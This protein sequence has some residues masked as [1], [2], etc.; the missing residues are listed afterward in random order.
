MSE[1]TQILPPNPYVGP[2]SF[3]TGEKMYGRDAE[4][5]ELV[6]LLIAERILVLHSPS[7]AGKSSLVQA[8]LIP[9]LQKEDFHVFPILRLNLD[10]PSNCSGQ[11]E[12]NRYAFS[13]MMSLEEGLDDA[14]KHPVE[15]LNAWTLEEYLAQRE[16]PQGEPDSKLLILDQFEEILTVDPNDHTGKTAFFAQLGSLLLNRKYWAL[17]AI[18]EDYVAA[19]DPYLR[20]VPTRLSNHF[21]LDLLAAPAA[22]QAIQK[23]AQEEGV[24]FQP[25]AVKKLVNDLRQIRVQQT[26]GSTQVQSGLYVEPVQLQVVCYNLWQHLP[27]GIKEITLKELS[28]IG[29][30]DQSL[31]NY[32]AE[33]VCSTSE[34]FQLP[35]RRIRNWFEHQLI[36]KQGIRGLVQMDAQESEGLDNRAIRRL[37]NDHLVRSEKRL[38]S[39]WFELAHDRL[40]DP[41]RKNNAVWMQQNLNL[42]QRQAGV[43]SQ[44][45]RPDSLLLQGKDLEDAR[46]WSEAN[47]GAM[48][49]EEKDFL[50]DCLIEEERRQTQRDQQRMEQEAREQALKLEAAESLANSEKRRAEEQ[51][52]AAKSLRQRAVFLAMALVLALG[53]AGVAYFLSRV[54]TKESNN[55]KLQ[56]VNAEVQRQ[57]AVDAKSIAEGAQRTSDANA[58]SA[59]SAQKTSDYNFQLANAE[60]VKAD[61]ASV[62]AIQQ[63]QTAVAES[64]LRATAQAQITRSRADALAAITYILDSQPDLRALLSIEAY[65]MLDTPQTRLALLSTLQQGQKMSFTLYG[66][67]IQAETTPIT[68]MS[69]QTD[70]KYAAWANNDG[71]VVFYDVNKQEEVWRARKHSGAVPGL[72]LCNAGGNEVLATGGV[73]NYV[74]EWNVSGGTVN[75]SQRTPN[76]INAVAM[77]SDCSQIAAAAGGA[78]VLYN[79]SD[80]TVID[81][82]DQPMAVND[83]AYSPDGRYLAIGLMNGRIMIYNPDTREAPF[84]LGYQTGGITSLVWMPDSLTLVSTGQD[85]TVLTW[86]TE[87]RERENSYRKDIVGKTDSLAV[88]PDGRLLAV[89]QGRGQV[90]VWD[91]ES[92]TPLK[93]Q[94][95]TNDIEHIAFASNQGKLIL[96]S[97]GLDKRVV[98]T[99]IRIQQR[100]SSVVNTQ[101][102]ASYALEISQ[103]GTLMSAGPAQNGIGIL[104]L[105]S[106]QIIPAGVEANA[107]EVALSPDGTKLAT[108][109]LEGTITIVSGVDQGQPAP[110]PVIPA[111]SSAIAGL[112]FSPD[113][114]TLASADCLQETGSGSR[115]ICT[116]S[117]IQFWDAA[118]GGSVRGPLTYTGDQVISLAYSPDGKSLAGGSFSKLL[119]WDLEKGQLVKQIPLTG[120]FQSWITSLAYSP[121]Q[122]TLAIGSGDAWVGLVDLSSS[123]S[124]SPTLKT[125]SQALSLVY[126]PTGN[127]FYSG[128]DDGSILRWDANPDLWVTKA[129]QFAGRNMAELTE[130]DRYLPGDP[131]RATCPQ[132]PSGAPEG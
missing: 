18:R 74:R 38:G 16:V 44:Q 67:G 119:I 11:S 19:L 3:Q 118:S 21:R 20:A 1:N 33:K 124:Y 122:K 91:L 117:E 95:Q 92:N 83:I 22:L 85:Q 110:L 25:E 51:T 102:P 39:T 46:Q 43:W 56:A 30:V 107:I 106:K 65:H 59:V 36:T 13:V 29:D 87:L 24:T 61:A 100:L 121:D 4:V 112:A 52:K 58:R 45:G 93:Q 132:F 41:I 99:E 104:N 69:I 34:A 63:A 60:K 126:D 127:Y 27:P 111:A 17:F 80:G 6:D 7:G 75:W 81:K 128:Q 66:Y 35:E 97:T 64:H 9:R 15:Q 76:V 26:D 84:T 129:C 114:Q 88:S 90:Q 89:G 12:C 49:D 98:L 50:A 103:D 125:N 130:W 113:A 105:K 5:R 55:A 96:A 37:E 71:E 32:Y 77:P 109:T 115:R 131:Y 40:I 62:K 73:D 78:V 116:Q 48:T 8:G 53:L 79:A 101:G 42:L 123:T 70:G 54:A 28:D 82:L 57:T 23:P 68:H 120:S 108:G 72:A 31:A 2:R 47:A 10:L 86:N 94:I 14:H